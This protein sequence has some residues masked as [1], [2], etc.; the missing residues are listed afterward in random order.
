MSGTEIANIIMQ[1][2]TLVTALTALIAGI[3]A[4][5]ITLRTK[6]AVK[7]QGIKS[8]IAAE[9]VKA[10]VYTA[11]AKTEKVAEDVKTALGVETIRTDNIQLDMTR[12]LDTTHALVNSHKGIMLD[13][14]AT[15]LEKVVRTE[16]TEAN[17]YEAEI[18]RKECDDHNKE[19]EKIDKAIYKHK[20]K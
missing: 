6:E 15:A 7:A 16:P 17:I 12:V 9:E 1:I 19:Q 2:T 10:A 14:K 18:A 5:V 13:Q 11:E 3:A 4:F 8:D 20:P